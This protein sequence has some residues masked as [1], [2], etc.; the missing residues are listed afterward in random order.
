[1]GEGY[2]V[3]GNGQAFC[4]ERF[5]AAGSPT[6]ELVFATGMCGYMETLSDPSYYGQIVMQTFPLIGNYGAIR[7]DMESGKTYAAA[8][9]VREKCEAPSNFR[10]GGTLDS[11]LKEQ[12]I[13]GLCG[14]D[15]REITR[16]IRETGVMNARIVDTLT[17]DSFSGLAGFTIKNAVAAVSRKEPC[18]YP[19]KGERRFFVALLD[20]GAKQNIIRSL[21]ERGCDVLVLPY[22]TPAGKILAHKP[23]G[24]MVS[25]GPGDPAENTGVIRELRALLG[26]IPIFGICLGH[27]LLALAA[28]GNTVKLKYG[29]RGVNQPVR[30]I[31]TGRVYM[32]SQNHGYAVAGESLSRCGAILRMHNANDGTCEG[33]DYPRWLAFSVQFHPEGC[34]GP[35]DTAFLFDRFLRLMEGEAAC[36]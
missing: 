1:M 4:G 23:D 29:H 30:D 20:C 7:E 26:E 9:V 22:D 18:V 28:G 19:V 13:P 36:L 3:L 11:F 16:V 10:A 34:C 6:G 24:L 2:L 27:Q 5:G 25:N 14:V 12:G 32:T 33:V 17:D 35:R 15:T 31:L 8:Y 21:N